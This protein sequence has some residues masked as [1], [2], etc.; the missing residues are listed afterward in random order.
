M[1][2]LIADR[3]SLQPA[4]EPKLYAR[5]RRKTLGWRSDNKEGGRTNVPGNAQNAPWLLA[6]SRWAGFRTASSL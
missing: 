3:A 1:P 5:V 6:T 2:T 4:D